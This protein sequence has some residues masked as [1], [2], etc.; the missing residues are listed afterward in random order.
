M[1]DELRRFWEK[2]VGEQVREIRLRLTMTQL[3][4]AR[5]LK[6]SQAA[7]SIME[8]GVNGLPRGSTVNRVAG[9]LGVKVVY[10]NL[11]PPWMEGAVPE[12]EVEW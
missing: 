10:G 9:A 8:K 12:G 5:R 3:E 2:P 7:V 1:T 4:L 11:M 6:V